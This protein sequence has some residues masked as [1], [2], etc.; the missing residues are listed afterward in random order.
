MLILWHEKQTFIR[1]KTVGGH[2]R[3]DEGR[4]QAPP[5]QSLPSH[6]QAISEG[7]GKTVRYN[8]YLLPDSRADGQC[9]VCRKEKAVVQTPPVFCLYCA[10]KFWRYK[11]LPA[12]K[13]EIC[14]IS[15]SA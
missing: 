10:R 6:G 14:R 3:Q 2:R 11:E 12:A 5:S 7:E 4:G 15:S 13:E 9:A 1:S 8:G